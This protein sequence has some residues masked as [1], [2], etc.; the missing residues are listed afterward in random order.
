MKSDL[1]FEA[2]QD[3]KKMLHKIIS[4]AYYKTK[5]ENLA[6]SDIL[7]SYDI[8]LSKHCHFYFLNYT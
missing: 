6:L 8:Y 1:D 7:Q 3:E 4:D 5:N 2:S